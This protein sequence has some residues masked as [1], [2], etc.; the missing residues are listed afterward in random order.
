MFRHQVPKHV[1]TLIS[2]VN[3]I[4]LS[5]FLGGYNDCK[6]MHNM[7]NINWL[8]MLFMITDTI[9]ACAISF[10]RRHIYCHTPSAHRFFGIYVLPIGCFL[11]TCIY[12][13]Q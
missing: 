1:G 2:A 5:T 12:L 7:N 3:L 6:S 10:S 4:L 9:T 8:I 13:I 11:V